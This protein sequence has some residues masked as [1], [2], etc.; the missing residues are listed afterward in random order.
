[1]VICWWRCSGRYLPPL[2]LAAAL[3]LGA[4]FIGYA[5]VQSRAERLLMAEIVLPG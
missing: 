4:H 5:V 1:M 3:P 2:R